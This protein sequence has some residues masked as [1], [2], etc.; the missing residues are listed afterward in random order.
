VAGSR[1][2][3]AHA[4]ARVLASQGRGVAVPCAGHRHPG[5]AARR[6]GGG[7]T[8]AAGMTAVRRVPAR[9][10]GTAAGGEWEVLRPGYGGFIGIAGSR[11]E[12]EGAAAVKLIGRAE[13]GGARG[14]IEVRPVGRSHAGCAAALVSSCGRR[15]GED[16]P[17]AVAA[18]SSSSS[19]PPSS[20][21]LV[22]RRRKGKGARVARVCGAA[23]SGFYGATLGL[24]AWAR[25]PR[26]AMPGVCA[27]AT[28][29]ASGGC[30][31]G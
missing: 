18:S 8:A 3:G 11:G 13:E 14:S 28:R 21:L 15:L 29:R 31:G 27:M 30:G 16:A 10:G 6:S 19:S 22:W 12:R 26:A 20:P 5:H 23:T 25:T 9:K 24:A 17:A 7:A 2:T 4:R 1:G